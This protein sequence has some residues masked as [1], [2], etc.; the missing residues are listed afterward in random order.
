MPSKKTK[1]ELSFFNFFD[2]FINDSKKGK[3]LQPNGKRITQGTIANYGNTRRVLENFCLV[4]N[5]KL[6]LRPDPSTETNTKAGYYK[7]L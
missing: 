7:N 4:K 5:F 1:K 3:R 6:R 2:K